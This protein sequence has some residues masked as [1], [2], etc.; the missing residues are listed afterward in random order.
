[1]KT[2]LLLFSAL[3][4]SLLVSFSTQANQTLIKEVESQTPCFSG[5]FE[6]YDSWFN[7][8]YAARKTRFKRQDVEDIKSKLDAFEAG[9]KQMFTPVA[10]Q[11]AKENL[12]CDF[13]TYNVDGETVKGVLITPKSIDASVPVIIY[14]RGGT[15]NF[16]SLVF[17]HVAARLFPLALEGYA[18][19]ASNYR[20]NEQYGA[21]NID[22]VTS[23]FSIIDSHDGI[24]SEQVGVYGTSRGG[25]TSWQLAAREPSRISAIVTSSGVTDAKMWAEN[26]PSIR[27]NI[28]SIKGFKDDPESI[29]NRL[30]PIEWVEKASSAPALIMHSRDDDKVSAQHSLK[31][32]QTL[33]TLDRV[34]KL[35]I[36][37]DGGHS[38]GVHSEKAFVDTIDWFDQYLK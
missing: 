22:E 27:N 15:R 30:S 12:T 26:R 25:L 19:I 8:L 9:F 31:M 21:D 7:W 29:F 35:T 24:N 38:L 14:N 23:L 18:V 6:T 2:N 16:G 32:A 4:F 11:N 13:F 3:F 33:S 36:Y 17:G 5:V 28:S 1:M 10:F 34:Y 37:E 20:E